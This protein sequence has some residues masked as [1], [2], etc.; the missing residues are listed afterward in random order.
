MDESLVLDAANDLAACG[1]QID[2]NRSAARE[3]AA[4]LDEAQLFWRPGRNAWSIAECFLHM[5]VTARLYLDAIDLGI[6][7]ARARGVT[8]TAPYRHPWLARW[9]VRSFEPPPAIRFP[10]PRPFRPTPPPEPPFA[11]IL[12]EFLRLGEAIRT[13]LDA[14]K[15]LDLGRARVVSPASPLIRLSLGLAFSLLAVH[16]RRHLYQAT[17]V[18][19]HPGFPAA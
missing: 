4:R 1:R 5:E 10:A 2:A 15:G 19:R 12:D 18:T 14:A 8:A 11:P 3:L 9:F 6:E 17:N 16:E 13:R 7:R